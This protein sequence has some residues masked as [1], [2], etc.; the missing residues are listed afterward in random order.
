MERETER[1]SGER[2]SGER[3][4]VEEDIW[5]KRSIEISHIKGCRMLP[6]REGIWRLD[7]VLFW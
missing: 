6:W 3:E 4:R 7:V 5:K 2:E 1:E